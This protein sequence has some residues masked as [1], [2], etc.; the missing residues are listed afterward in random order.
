MEK[1]KLLYSAPNLSFFFNTSL[2]A[3]QRRGERLK[4][5]LFVCKDDV[6]KNYFIDLLGSRCPDNGIRYANFSAINERGVLGATLTNLNETDLLVLNDQ[7]TNLSSE[8][9]GILKDAIGNFAIE[10]TLGKGPSSRVIR[11]DLPQFT[12]VAC[13]SEISNAI[14]ELLPEF[15]Y[16]LEVDC[17]KT[18]KKAVEMFC[19]K[20]NVVFDEEAVEKTVCYSG[21]QS[22][23][24]ETYIKRISEYISYN[25]KERRISEKQFDEIVDFLNLPKTKTSKTPTK[26]KSDV[27]RKL[28]EIIFRLERIEKELREI[29]EDDRIDSIRDILENNG[30]F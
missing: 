21:G 14:E 17:E 8:C 12:L 23:K 11:L 15:E 28:E 16:V 27:E 5:I 3:I 18:C 9:V 30:L 4:H 1:E 29:K 24:A 7:K 26:E 25:G 19:E 20:E 10:I 13:V 2:P 6:I 22:N